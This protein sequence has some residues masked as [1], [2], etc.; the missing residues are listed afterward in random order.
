MFVHLVRLQSLKLTTTGQVLK[1]T[2]AVL[3]HKLYTVARKKLALLKKCL[4]DVLVNKMILKL[5]KTCQKTLLKLY[6][7]V[8]FGKYL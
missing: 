8:V 5:Y 4:G 3:F 6:L 7:F 1:I 2:L